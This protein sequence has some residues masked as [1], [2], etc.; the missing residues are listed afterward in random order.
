MVAKFPSILSLQLVT[1]SASYSHVASFKRLFN[2]IVTE[3][4]SLSHDI[5]TFGRNGADVVGASTYNLES[6]LSI[7]VQRLG[8][9]VV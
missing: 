2:G 6:E 9:S 4:V 5:D 1:F 8:L 7:F 3:C